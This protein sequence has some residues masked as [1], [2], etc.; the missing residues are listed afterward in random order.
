MPETPQQYT[1][2]ILG[3]IDNKEPLQVQQS[4]PKKL[5]SLIRKLNKKTTHQASR[6]ARKM[7]DRGDSRPSGGYRISRRLAYA[8]DFEP[9]RHPGT[10]VRSGCLGKHFQ[11]HPA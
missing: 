1:Q 10:G 5:S 8:D 6:A 11:L 4:T 3:H 7:V 2:R 9:E